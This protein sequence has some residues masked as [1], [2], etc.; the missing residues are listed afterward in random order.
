[1]SRTFIGKVLNYKR[2]INLKYW[3]VIHDLLA[4]SQHKDMVG[5]IVKATGI[6][7]PKFSMFGDIKEGDLV[8]YYATKDYVVTGIFLVISDI[9]Y[10]PNDPYWKEIMVYKMKPVAT[11]PP[12]KYL[13]FKKLVKDPKVNL[14][15]IPNKKRWGIYLQGKT[16]ILLTISD[17][18]TILN[19]LSNTDYLKSIDKIKIAPTRWHVEH[20][21][22]DS[23]QIGK[24][25][26]HQQ[27][28]MKWKD[29]EEKKFGLF[30]PDIKTNT[31]DINEILP[32]SVWLKENTK[33]VDGLARLEIGGQSIYQSILEVQHRG[34]KED[35]C[36]RV[37]IILPFVTRIDIVSD[38]NSLL[39]IQELLERIA[40][41]NIVKSRV[42]FYSFREFLG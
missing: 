29:E 2:G 15:M 39:K 26:R 42:K 35:L 3:F 9:E 6:K 34:S 38:E 27:A 40:D 21:K 18:R 16:C 30:K 19:S 17:Y 36:V 8:V 11:P 5:N 7:Q 41:P 37:S 25:G 33:Y 13:N 12:G 32:K 31:V 22:K 28:V 1:M 24:V 23:K 20:G 14:E 10:L 4:Y